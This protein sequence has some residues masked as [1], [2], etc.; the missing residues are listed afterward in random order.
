MIA[1]T[2][3]MRRV[4]RAAKSVDMS[5]V[6]RW[7]VYLNAVDEGRGLVDHR[8][9]KVALDGQRGIGRSGQGLDASLPARGCGFQKSLHQTGKTLCI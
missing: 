2:A 8:V 3:Q 9:K 4:E 5:E 1:Q 6:Y 7:I